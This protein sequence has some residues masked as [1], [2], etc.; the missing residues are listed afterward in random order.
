[1]LETIREFGLEQ[2]EASGE[3]DAVRR[4][5]AEWCLGLAEQAA[6]HR[7]QEGGSATWLDRLDR[8]HDD[9]WAAL[10]WLEGAGDPEAFL[11]LTAALG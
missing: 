5:H 9:L 4:R 8:D 6:Q 3:G 10:T 2:L 11:R 7:L 1:M